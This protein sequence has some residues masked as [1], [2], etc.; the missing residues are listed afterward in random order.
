M[1]EAIAA[2]YLGI[3]A[4]KAKFDTLLLDP[5]RQTEEQVCSQLARWRL[6]LVEVIG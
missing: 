2:F 5:R 1:L 4:S 6:W 3:G